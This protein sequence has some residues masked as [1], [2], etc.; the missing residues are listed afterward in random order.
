MKLTQTDKEIAA[1]WIREKCGQMRCVCCGHGKWELIEFS[2]LAIGFDVRTT[3]FHYHDGL[4]M[5]TVAC[6]NCAHLV[7]FSP[8]MMGI[9]PDAP[10]SEAKKE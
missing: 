5:V 6:T 10:T 4:P 2:T 3:R 1:K 9:K 7:N 8:G